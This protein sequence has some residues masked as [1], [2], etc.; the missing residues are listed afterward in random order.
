VPVPQPAFD[1]LLR[2]RDRKQRNRRIGAGVV[3][4]VVMLSATVA[5]V[6]AFQSERLPADRPEPSPTTGRVGFVGLPPEGAHPSAPPT[7]GL[8]ISLNGYAPN[9]VATDLYVYADGTMIW[10]QW[11]FAGPPARPEPVGVPEG[12]NQFATG[13]LEQR[14]TP[15][16]VELLRSR[17]L[18]TGLFEH[19]MELRPGTSLPLTIGVRRGDRVVSVSVL[20]GP[21]AGTQDVTPAMVRALRDLETA[22]ADP[23]TW[24]PTTAWADREIRAYVASRY[25]GGFDRRVPSASEFPPP[26]ADLLFG[27]QT[28]R[29]F[30]IA[31]ARTISKA[32]DA[33]GFAHS[34]SSDGQLTYEIYSPSDP[35]YPAVLHFWPVVPN[36]STFQGWP[37][38]EFPRC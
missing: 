13:Y 28:C 16:G 29:D 19:T 30:T 25:S 32:L 9:G 8:V 18:S 23:A 15:G 35:G 37:E 21:P 34:I 26:A 17:I 1:R 12:A 5:L 31:E 14:L 22:L 10:Q 11:S 3:A 27:R 6:R 4:F 20:E 2:R 38:G 24:L 33:A 7:A 36:L